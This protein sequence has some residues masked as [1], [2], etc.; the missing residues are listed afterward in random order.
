[1]IHHISLTIHDVDEVRNFYEDVLLCTVGHSFRLHPELSSLIFSIEGEPEV[2]MV[3]HQGITLE[4]FL[5]PE[6]ERRAYSHV[7]LAYWKSEMIFEAALRGGYPALVKERKGH[8]TYF[9][10]DKAGN[11]FEIKEMEDDEQGE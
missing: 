8:D 1:M 5:S 3:R 7:C 2:F 10:R 6:T 4:L 11:L 9:I